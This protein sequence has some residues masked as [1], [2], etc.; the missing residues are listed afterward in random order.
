MERRDLWRHVPLAF[1]VAMA[2]TLASGLSPIFPL[3]QA[4]AA[5]TSAQ[6][7]TAAL[8]A[9]PT[10]IAETG[11]MAGQAGTDGGAATYQVP[12]VVP[13]GRAGMQPSLSLNYNS[14]NGDGIAGMGWSISGLSSI[15]RCPQTPEQDG[16]TRGVSYS[17]TDRL[18]L[19]GQRLVSVD[20]GYGNS[21]TVYRTEIDSYARVTQMSGNLASS[22]TWFKVE[23][24][25]G[26]ILNYGNSAN[27]RVQPAGAAAPLSWLVDKVQDRVGNFQSYSYTNFGNGEIL[28]G[29][30]TY[31]GLDTSLGTVAGNRSVE[32]SYQTRTAAAAGAQDIASSALAGGMT[33]QTRALESIRSKIDGAVVRKYVPAYEKA[34]YSGRLLMTSLKECAGEFAPCHPPTLFSYNDGDLN[35]Q[36]KS[37]AG[38][39]LASPLPDSG[40]NNELYQLRVA[41][42]YDGDGTREAVV[43]VAAGPN[44]GAYL[45]QFTGDRRANI[46]A[47]ITGAYGALGSPQVSEADMDGSGR[48]ALIGLPQLDTSNVAFGLWNYQAYPRGAPASGNPFGKVRTD[49]A[50]PGFAIGIHKQVLAADVDADG[51]T[52]VLTIA[53]ESCGS[54]GFGNRNGVFLNRNVSNGQFVIGTE[55]HF[56]A[57]RLL[58]CLPR[59]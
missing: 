11:T 52:D 22:T 18:C 12:I 58:F 13:P 14:R 8:D 2:L 9:A 57:R 51:K 26:R 38:L 21:G 41:G 17:S 40:E 5:G 32:F 56:E 44:S 46:S 19:D 37:L 42:D 24:K 43:K 39:G 3:R 35:F 30:V 25:N 15:H 59:I 28:L 54:D 50:L 31:T 45:T 1:V 4:L 7:A 49:I 29:T 34:R 23:Q 27:S 33:L 47:S 16:A 20:G 6:A 10:H 36:L 48:A 53:P 55:V